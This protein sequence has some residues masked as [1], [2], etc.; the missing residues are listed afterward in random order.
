M[1]S[2]FGIKKRLYKS[3]Q[4]RQRAF[5][6]DRYQAARACDIRHQN[7]RQPPLSVLAA[8]DAPP[9]SGKVN[10]HIA[11]SN[12]ANSSPV[13]DHFTRPA[14]YF[15]KVSMRYLP[16]KDTTCRF[17]AIWRRHPSPQHLRHREKSRN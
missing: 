1:I 16:T 14:S 9:G 17:A 2:D 5:F 13:D 7:S 12:E 11:Q 8:Q 4:L 15:G 10:V 6:V 3:F